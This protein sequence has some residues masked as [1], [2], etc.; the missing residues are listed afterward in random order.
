MVRLARQPENQHTEFQAIFLIIFLKQ[1]VYYYEI[2][3]YRFINCHADQPQYRITRRNR[4]AHR[5]YQT[6]L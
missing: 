1:G 2:Q 3:A 6:R 5:R 4:I